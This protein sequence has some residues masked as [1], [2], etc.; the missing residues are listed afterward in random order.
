[1][2]NTIHR[3]SEYDIPTQNRTGNKRP[4]PIRV[5]LDEEIEERVNQFRI[6]DSRG[7]TS[8]INKLLKEALDTRDALRKCKDAS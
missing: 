4:N 2:T 1:M 7:M 8:A 5:R 6:E 3:V